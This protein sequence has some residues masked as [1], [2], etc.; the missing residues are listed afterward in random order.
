MQSLLQGMEGLTSGDEPVW[1]CCRAV[2]N[3]EALNVLV[4]RDFWR[5]F[6]VP[7]AIQDRA[8]NHSKSTLNFRC[9]QEGSFLDYDLPGVQLHCLHSE[10]I[11]CCMLRVHGY[12]LWMPAHRRTSACE[13]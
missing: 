8:L 5:I 1:V 10:L 3:V 7:G 2:L 12:W 11:A 13:A 9:V 4:L 6:S